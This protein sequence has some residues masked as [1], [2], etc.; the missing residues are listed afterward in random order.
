M[1]TNDE[2]DDLRPEYDFASLS[3]VV[4]G[5]YAEQFREE[6]ERIVLATGEVIETAPLA[7]ADLR[8]LLA[9]SADGSDWMSPEMDIY[10]E[11]DKHRPLE[12]KADENKPSL[13]DGKV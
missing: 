7:H 10:D 5:K 8:Q 13:P 11:Y 6:V 2:T 9:E 4:R 1:S 3:G 12:Q